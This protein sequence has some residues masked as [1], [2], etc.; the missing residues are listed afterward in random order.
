MTHVIK[1]L[2]WANGALC[3]HINQYVETF[4]HDAHDGAG[5]GEFTPDIDKAMKFKSAAEAMQF[6]N[7]QST[8][9][10]LRPDG[11]PNKPLTAAHCEITNADDGTVD[12]V[13]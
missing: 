9:R 5:Y 2:G 13:R 3:P 6:W 7:K 8:A 10:P 11:K 4:D 12:E 1:I